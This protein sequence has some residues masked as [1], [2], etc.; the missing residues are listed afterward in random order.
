MRI[1]EI[2]KQRDTN[3]YVPFDGQLVS[4]EGRVLEQSETASEHH[5]LLK[6][7]ATLFP[8]K[9]AKS[10]LGGESLT[11]TDSVIRVTGI[12]SAVKDRNG[13][14]ESIEILARSGHDLLVLVQPS[15][16]SIRHVIEALAAG[17]L[18]ILGS[19]GFI[20]A[21]RRQISRQ[22]RALDSSLKSRRALLNAVPMLTV[23]ADLDGHVIECSEHVSR[24]L[25]KTTQELIG[26]EW[27]NVCKPGN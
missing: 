18:V 7:G 24:L 6:Q 10:A 20:Y 25:G 9:I 19:I 1:A 4:T 26:K 14:P 5:L 17:V 27:A 15:W 3:F 2:I 21:Q 22:E 8:V 12:C 11:L 16:W 23:F 13:D